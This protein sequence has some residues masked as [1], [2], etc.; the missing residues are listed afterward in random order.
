MRIVAG[1]HKGRRIRT[2]A[3]QDIRPTSE[4]TRE[5]LF[6]ILAAGRLSRD[7][8]DS[9]LGQRVL[10]AFAGTGALGLEAL[11]RGAAEVVFLERSAAARTLCRA[12]LEA[13]GE[14]EK[15]EVIA[16]DALRPPAAT[17]PCG[18]ILMDPPYRKD[19]AGPALVALD[20][21]GWV[22]PLALVAV[23]LTSR[24]TFAPPEGFALLD[25]RTYG[26]SKLV[27]ARRS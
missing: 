2:P 5:A 15:G 27:F 6:N 12:N 26:K 19:L 21:A 22:A 18:L 14:T 1:R 11:S 9:I 10:D 25:I 13:F 16:C 17:A 3:D 24:E 7:G 8:R 23:E 4:R 20:G